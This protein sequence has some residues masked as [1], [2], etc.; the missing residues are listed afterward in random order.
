VNII[1]EE[2]KPLPEV[3]IACLA[4]SKHRVHDGGIFCRLIVSTE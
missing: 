4:A 1:Q 2:D 3:D